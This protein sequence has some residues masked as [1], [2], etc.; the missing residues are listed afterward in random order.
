MTDAPIKGTKKALEAAEACGGVAVFPRFPTDSPA[1]TDRTDWN[2]LYLEQGLDAVR[3]QL[4]AALADAKGLSLKVANEGGSRES[5]AR[6][7]KGEN[8]GPPIENGD[9]GALTEDTLATAFECAHAG[10]VHYAHAFGRWYVYNGASGIWSWDREELVAN[11]VRE[12]VRDLN[13][14]QREKW[15]KAAVVS[16]VAKLARRHPAIA[17]SGMEFDNN[18]MLLGTP[19]GPIDLSTAEALTPSW[20]HMVSKSTSVAR[21]SG[22]PKLWL[23]TLLFASGGDTD[24]VDYLQRLFGYCLTGHTSE[25]SLEF[26][27]GSGG[28]GKG[29][30]MNTV[31]A[32]AGDYG[33]QASMDTFIRSRN[34]R[35]PA[36]LADLVGARL[37]IAAESAE[38]AR[39]D[40]QRVKM[41]TGRDRISARFMRGNFFEFQPA[42]TLLIASNHK[43]R[44]G[45][46]DDAWRRRLH[47][48]P[49]DRKPAKAD[50]ELKD[51][52][53]A[54]YPQILAWMIEGAEWWSRDGLMPPDSV[55]TATEE[56]LAEE[57]VIGI[58]FRECC[59]AAGAQEKA[60]RI[61]L[62]RSFES[63]CHQ[64]G[65][66]ASSLH[67][68]TR[69]LKAQ[70]YRQAE[71]RED[72][73]RPFFGIKL[74]S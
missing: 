61:D 39:W 8:S 71:S 42:F 12:F 53:R 1:T 29:V 56:Y 37:V 72:K 55:V 32:I 54:E 4:T 52:L 31:L 18:P 5:V 13:R 68:V 30:V 21:A 2:D 59:E 20:K 57:D 69:W 15:G 43:P 9:V 22:K 24:L 73:A 50:H 38:G 26:F 11:W 3:E 45:T 17:I 19:A 63:W 36:D 74:C 28:N 51:K 65:H 60:Y 49:F 67:K 46:V 27:H 7:T 40:E 35:H 58:W 44:I 10:K 48:I 14:E 70:G 25:E 41:A 33:R 23:D 62:Y 66:A 16:A 34:D 64:M 6:T 47:L